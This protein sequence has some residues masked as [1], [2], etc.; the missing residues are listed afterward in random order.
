M[1]ERHAWAQAAGTWLAD[2]IARDAHPPVLGVCFGHQLLADVLG[3][4]VDWCTHGNLGTSTLRAEHDACEADEL[5][6]VVRDRRAMLVQVAHRQCVHE[7]PRGAVVLMRSAAND[8]AY[9]ARLAP[10]VWGVQYHP[11]MSEQGVKAIIARSRERLLREGPHPDAIAA[12]VRPTPDG[13]LVLRRFVEL[14]LDHW[15]GL[16]G[17][18]RSGARPGTSRDG[19]GGDGEARAAAAKA[20]L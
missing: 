2:G 13:G 15:T 7:L 9:V 14:C 17:G 18:A 5:F 1:T 10:R 20:R 4:R 6:S 11:E 19:R 12:A 3:G 16:A 8:H